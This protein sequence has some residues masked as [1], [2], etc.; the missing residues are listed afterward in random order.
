[1]NSN[2]KQIQV[3]EDEI[4]VAKDICAILSGSGYKV[5]GISSDFESGLSLFKSETPDL[6]ICDINLG[7]GKSGIDLINEIRLIQNIPVIYLTA[8]TD[9]ETVNSALKSTPESYLTKP[10]TSEQLLISVSR[11]LGSMADIEPDNNRAEP[12]TRREMDVLQ[13]IALGDSSKA[14]AKKLCI[15][16]ET[17][18]SHRKNLLHKYEV[19]SSSELIAFAHKNEWLN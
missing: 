1:M 15:S 19:S 12:P 11:V 9:D 17:V 5:T 6:I 10:F 8:Y 14:I 18:Q 2:H 4:I 16:F 3:V 7:R 13:L